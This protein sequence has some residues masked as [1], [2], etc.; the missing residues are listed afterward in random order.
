MVDVMSPLSVC[1]VGAQ[2]IDTAAV[3][4]RR[5]ADHALT[6]ADAA[7]LQMMQEREIDSCW[8]T[9]YHLGLT[10]V[11]LVIHQR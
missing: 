11:P 10:G 2:E 3:L 8:S 6:L 4:L 7:G 1:A 9:D 5:F